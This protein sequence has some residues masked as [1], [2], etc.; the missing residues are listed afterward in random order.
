MIMRTILKSEEK[1]MVICVA[2]KKGNE[3]WDMVRDSKN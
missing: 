2:P 3:A 1:Y